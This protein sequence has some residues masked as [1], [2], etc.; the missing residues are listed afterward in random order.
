MKKAVVFAVVLGF[1][2]FTAASAGA[3]GLAPSANK[4]VADGVVGPK[5]YSM[6][7]TYSGMTLGSS[8]SSDGKTV[9]FA[10]EAPTTGWVAIG[11]GSNRMNGAFMVL[12]SDAKGTTVVSEQTGRGHSH[13]PN[14]VKKLASG[15]VKE[16]KGN[17]V[18]EFSLP[19]AEYIKGT[20]LQ[21]LIAF[22]TGDDI[23]TKHEKYASLD[24]PLS[25]P[26]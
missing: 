22:G 21:M 26:K 7:G 20:S 5:E 11:L 19:A 8:L 6:T 15:A 10:L 16:N 24:L 4:P 1:L 12:A 25:L 2:G 23:T 3:Q 14:A 18:L 9:Y 17:T 13:S